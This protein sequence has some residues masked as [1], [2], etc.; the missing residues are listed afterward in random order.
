MQGSSR[1][2]TYTGSCISSPPTSIRASTGPHIALQCPVTPHIFCGARGRFRAVM[3][4]FL[5]SVLPTPVSTVRQHG[6]PSITPLT[7]EVR[8]A[9]TAAATEWR[10]VS[11]SGAWV[12][13]AGVWPRSPARRCFPPVFSC[14]PTS[15]GGRTERG[16]P[17]GHNP[18]S[19]AGTRTAPS[20]W[21]NEMERGLGAGDNLAS[22][23]PSPYSSN[24]P[25]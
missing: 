20:A 2:A 23:V 9:A 3:T 11:G 4:P 19:R 13:T 25:L 5:T 15:S 8:A 6:R 24:M 1:S 10:P 14:P 7:W 17:V 18:S 22:Y 21:R 16:G 12:T